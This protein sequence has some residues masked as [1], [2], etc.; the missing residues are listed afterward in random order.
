M[1]GK[2]RDGDCGKGSRRN[3]KGRISSGRKEPGKIKRK[4]GGSTEIIELGVVCKKG[5]QGDIA[6]NVGIIG[7]K[8]G[9]REGDIVRTNCL[10][11]R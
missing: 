9:S 4:N 2:F 7:G 1:D 3:G 10:S 6:G 8:I 5:A 11:G